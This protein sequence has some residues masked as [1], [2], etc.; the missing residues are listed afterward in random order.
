MI[1]KELLWWKFGT[2]LLKWYFFPSQNSFKAYLSKRN[3]LQIFALIMSEFIAI[4]LCFCMFLNMCKAFFLVEMSIFDVY[5][6]IDIWKTFFVCRLDFTVIIFIHLRRFLMYALEL[7][8]VNGQIKK[9]WLLEICDIC[10]IVFVMK[11]RHL[12]LWWKDI[13][14]TGT[15]NSEQSLQEDNSTGFSLW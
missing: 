5:R 14:W 11:A 12:A 13:S 3:S 4:W 10:V 8:K 7:Y 6:I 2:I 15:L 1:G 9:L